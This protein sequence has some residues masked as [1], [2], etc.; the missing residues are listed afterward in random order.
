[1]KAKETPLEYFKRKTVVTKTGCWQWTG[2]V[3]PYG[4]GQASLN[5]KPQRAHRASY[6]Y[7]KG[8]ITDGYFIDH[9]CRNRACVNP[10]HLRAVTPAVNTLENSA[11]VTAYNKTKA[12]CNFGHPL[13][14]ENLVY[15]KG[16][17]FAIIGRVCRTCRNQANVRYRLARKKRRAP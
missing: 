6:K 2:C 1:M 3:A 11:G 7:L 14:G 4:Y 15:R 17:K 16:P 10:D 9:I 8:P 12:R 13:A 5:G